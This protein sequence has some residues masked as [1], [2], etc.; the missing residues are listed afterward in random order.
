MPGIKFVSQTIGCAH[1]YVSK[2]RHHTTISGCRN[3]FGIKPDPTIVERTVHM[4][5]DNPW[6]NEPHATLPNRLQL[7]AGPDEDGEGQ[8]RVQCD[9]VRPLHD[10]TIN[11]T[12]SSQNLYGSSKIAGWCYGPD[13]DQGRRG[14]FLSWSIEDGNTKVLLDCPPI[15]TDPRKQIEVSVPT[16]ITAEKSAEQ[17]LDSAATGVFA[18]PLSCRKPTGSDWKDGEFTCDQCHEGHCTPAKIPP[19][20]RLETK[21]ASDGKQ[22]MW[23]Y[24][25]WAD[26]LECTQSGVNE[27]KCNSLWGTQGEHDIKT[28]ARPLRPPQ[29][30]KAEHVCNA[31][32]S[33]LK[34]ESCVANHG[35]NGEVPLTVYVTYDNP[36]DSGCNKGRH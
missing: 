23:K 20:L 30:C 24:D 17:Q 21:T 7:F 18:S 14:C 1:N 12:A 35:G 32:E 33:E 10:D 6:M 28:P 27:M 15:A 16:D 13:G 2:D 34:V 19:T 25:L 31:G 8:D 22:A 26:D 4:T 36:K 29:S 11:L 9:F 3:T 5:I